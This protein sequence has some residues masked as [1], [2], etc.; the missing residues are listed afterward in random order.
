MENMLRRL[1]PEDIEI[2]IH[3]GQEACPVDADP[4]QLKQILMNLAVNARDAMPKG[5]NLTIDV[6]TVN[7]D[8]KVLQD[9]SLKWGPWVLLTVKDTG[10]GMD[11]E[12]TAHIF[13]PFFTT[14][15][16]GEGTG[17]GLST[18]YGIVHQYG[19]T[20]LVSSKPGAGSTF[21]VYL[22]RSL[23]SKA[24]VEAISIHRSTLNGHE[25]ILLVDDS[26]PLR[27]L[28]LELLYRRGYSV[29]QAG[30]GVSAL[31][32]SRKHPG[33]IHLLITD[34]VMPRMGGIELARCIVQER[35]DIAL[36]FV[37]GYAADACAMPHYPP[38]RIAIIEKPYK[39][40]TLLHTVRLMLDKMEVALR[41][42]C[43]RF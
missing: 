33:V 7:L 13:E 5:G 10:I 40:E 42:A 39:A 3:C 1:L 36:I 18:L 14:K 37:T 29:L 25:T 31:E 9:E 17:L 2:V 35:P 16:V 23:E 30:D 32:V 11:V 12:T 15:P 19:G 4:S 21:R 22:P 34:M 6:R 27:K 8:G 38:G 20:V 28:M 43:Q 26:A 41:G 24:N